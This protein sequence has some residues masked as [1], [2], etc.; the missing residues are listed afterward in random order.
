M[1]ANGA[2]GKEEELNV[3]CRR[4]E[5]LDAAQ[6]VSLATAR[7]T[8]VG[9][10]KGILL[11][12]DE[13]GGALRLTATDESMAI[14]VDLYAYVESGGGAVIANT[15]LFL[16][17]LALAPGEEITLALSTDGRTLEIKSEGKETQLYLTVL[18][19]ND[20]PKP[21]IPMPGDT[22]YVTGL[23]SLLAA[24]CLVAAGATGAPVLDCVKLTLSPNGIFAEAMGGFTLIK[25]EGDKEA[26]GD[27][28]I[29]LPTAA[30]RALARISSDRDVFE[31]GVAGA[32]GAPK[33]AVFFDG[34]LLFSAR[35][36]ECAFP[37]TEDI[38]RRQ[39][40]RPDV[41]ADV[42]AHEFKAALAVVTTS[43]SPQDA[44]ELSFG[45]EGI[46]LRC[47]TDGGVAE[48]FISAIGA[49]KVKASPDAYRFNKCLSEYVGTQ[50][51]VLTLD[52]SNGNLI[53]ESAGTRY[54]QL[55]MRPAETKKS[56]D[57][58]A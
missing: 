5:L 14:R 38:F 29:L 12:A 54:M 22:V 25:A 55:G 32:N 16:D 52:I 30:L 17:C 53:V 48:N 39:S 45:D 43:A 36:T 49:V 51:G 8:A 26:K 2:D 41:S 13:R 6:K 11:E 57:V 7:A 20:Y 31:F 47:E 40:G 15:K 18:P 24:P 33:T 10:R 35:L 42:H 27:I 3:N 58:A 44:V 4:K 9:V 23:K 28:S 37:D 56:K 46:F 19:E 34:T 21:E 50:R 1:S